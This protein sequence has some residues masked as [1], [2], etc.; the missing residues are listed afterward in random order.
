MAGTH[1]GKPLKPSPPPGREYWTVPTLAVP[2]RG[3]HMPRVIYR[4]E[5]SASEGEGCWAPNHH[6]L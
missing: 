2:S 1:T 4:G 6:L 3:A 5:L